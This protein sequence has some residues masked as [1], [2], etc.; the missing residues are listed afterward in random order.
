M[1]DFGPLIMVMTSGR[2]GSSLLC[3]LLANH[4]MWTGP[5]KDGD[6][7]NPDGFYE[8]MDVYKACDHYGQFKKE[9]GISKPA[10]E[11]PN[12]FKDLVRSQGY[13]SG[14]LVIKHI[15]NC[16]PIWDDMNP[17]YVTI[18]RN[19]EAQIKSREKIRKPLS[20]HAIEGREEVMDYLEQE[21]GAIRVD[22]ERL[23]TCDL[24][25]LDKIVKRVN[26]KLDK[27]MCRNF[28]NPQ[29]WHY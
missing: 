23:I 12:R 27:R 10:P 9:K 20:R 3:G 1:S 16:W 22:S 5:T 19:V 26:V 28:I 4:G 2:S 21:K 11:W 7:R 14:P 24:S 15:P 18:R 13:E 8:N 25:Q 6:R 29:Y 17:I